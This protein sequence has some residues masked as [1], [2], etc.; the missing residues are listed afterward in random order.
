MK[1]HKWI[2]I[3]LLPFL[4]FTAKASHIVGGEITFECLGDSSYRISL[5]VYRDCY[6]G[7]PLA[8]FDDPAHVG[9][10]NNQNML[11]MVIDMP[12]T[13]M[14]DTLSAIFNDPCLFDPGDV[15]VH[16]THYEKV[17]TLP[18]IPGGYQFVYQRCCRNQT[19]SNIYNPDQTGMTIVTYMSEQSMLECNNG[20]D[21][22]FIPP[23]FICVDKPID[24][25]HSAID[26]EG[27]SLVYKLCTPYEGA[28]YDDPYPDV[29]S[30]PPYDT[31]V[32]VDPPYNLDN[33][34]GT[35]SIPLAI[36]PHTGFMTG[37]PTNQGQYVVSV[38]VEEYRNG[39]LISSMRRDFQYNVGVCGEVT[40]TF[41][42]PEAQCDNLTVNFQNQ[43]STYASDFIWYFQYPDTTIFSME[44]NPAY[45]YPD[46][47]HY[48]IMLVA[49]PGSVCADTFVKDIYLQNNSLFA[50]FN[51]EVFDCSD[52]AVLSLQDLSQDTV[53]PPAYWQW[54]VS[55]NNISLS[56]NEQNPLFYLPSSVSGNIELLVQSVNG[57]EQ[58]LNLPF[59]TGQGFPGAF[60][61]DTAYACLGQTAYLNPQASQIQAAGY[62]WS[63]PELVSD[64]L[65]ANPYA[66]ADTT[67]QFTVEI[68]APD[69]LC[70][71]VKQITLL[72]LPYPELTTPDS[73]LLCP[74][75]SVVLN[76][77]GNPGYHYNWSSSGQPLSDPQ[78]VSPEVSPTESTLYTVE[79]TAPGP[80]T[81]VATRQVLVHVPPPIGLQAINDTVTCQSELSISAQTAEFTT[82]FWF[83]NGQ[84]ILPPVNPLNIQNIS[85]ENT[86]MVNAVDVYGCVASDTFTVA[87]GPVE[88]QTS[89][90]MAEVCT[91]EPLQIQTLNL[92]PNDSLSY[93]WAVTGSGSLSANDIPNPVYSSTSAGTEW[94]IGTFTSQYNCTAQDSV[95]VTSVSGN[96]Q[97]A[98]TY[99]ILCDG[100]TVQFTNQSTNVDS[101][102]WDFGVPDT[103][104]DTSTAVNPIFTFPELGSYQVTL[105]IPYA[106]DCALPATTTIDITNPILQAGFTY[107]YA[108]CEEDSI[109]VSFTDASTNTLTGNINAWQ[110]TFSNGQS[111]NE[112]NPSIYV[113]PGDSPLITELQ[114]FTTINCTSVITDTLEINFLE[115]FLPDT[116][117]LC[118][119]DTVQLNP[120]ADSSYTYSWSPAIG[121]NDPTSGSPLAFPDETTNYTLNISSFTGAD[122][123]Q[124]QRSITVFVPEALQLSTEP[125][126]SVIS[127]GVPV[128]IQANV[129]Q[130]A[131][132]VWTNQ[133]G[134]IIGTGPS[135]TVLPDSIE[136][137][138]LQAANSYNCTANDQIVVVNGT[139]NIQAEEELFLC[140]TDSFQLSLNNADP[141]DQIS[142]FWTAG[143]G[144]SVLSDPTQST[145]WAS[146]QTG[147]T[148]FYYQVENQ[149]GCSLEDS[150][151][152]YIS[153]FSA[154]TNDSVSACYGES[155]FINPQGNPAYDYLWIPATGLDD[156]TS[157]NPLATLTQDQ[158]YTVI[159]SNDDGLTVC[160][161]TQ[162]VLVSVSPDIALQLT[163]DQPTTLCESLDVSLEAGSSVPVDFSWYENQIDGAPFS[164][165]NPLSVTPDGTVTYYVLA[166]DAYGCIDTA[167]I[168]FEAYPLQLSIPTGQLSCAGDKIVLTV[169]NLDSAQQ[170]QYQWQPDSLID[171]I[172]PGQVS[173]TLYEDALIE[174]NISNQIGCTTSASIPVSVTDLQAQMFAEAE[175]DTLFLLADSL[176]SSQLTTLNLPGLV[177]Y[178][179][180][181]ESLSDAGIFN[182]LAFPEETTTYV[183][184]LEDENGC[185]A[186]AEV[187]VVVITPECREPVIFVPNSFTPNADGINDMLF[188]Y[189]N[190]QAEGFFT[191]FYFTVYNRWGQKLF[192]TRDPSQGWDGTFKGVP[193]E[194]DVFG[195]YLEVKCYNGETF[196]KKG[197][198]SLLR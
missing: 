67:R 186:E 18:P 194:P 162:Q 45:T 120:G 144:G 187:R 114:V 35:D 146:A 135:I 71:F 96:A 151:L 55:Y 90:G 92:D 149:F 51:F 134:I 111:S 126:D 167:S 107:Q 181:A 154:A 9:V 193:L 83:E 78:A 31:V 52:S 112:Q 185:Q 191:D 113:Y 76:P 121:L 4:A 109:L 198:V 104:T 97:L 15:C 24:F 128:L 122:T 13:G 133:D 86:Y 147:L 148:T 34:L 43:S 174:V 105:S 165:D 94:V 66:T 178:W 77:G 179:E 129:N 155:T 16:T 101:F 20:P 70:T 150:T 48:Q 184:I 171:L 132:Y 115:V 37:V 42:S 118:Q 29:P 2:F 182:P 12:F 65:A 168:T 27:D 11:V 17:V 80:D 169:E 53:S 156:S 152:V 39:Q 41:F 180:P 117:V 22:T 157:Y 23:I 44:E 95:L 102:V 40:A 175:P 192:E 63:P 47:G 163:A 172:G 127:C 46:T 88:V 85:G 91:G 38:C 61:P 1:F 64:S 69:S 68:Q 5:E 32:W 119:G 81:C 79:I 98:F 6:W 100:L 72:P 158:T 49:D 54:T 59:Q 189:G 196:F 25:D 106:V 28:T 176:Q 123:C 73:I 99:E 74:G 110:W 116:M 26:T 136:T 159:I 62:F 177:Y 21:F 195:Y 188:V 173:L 130:E 3:L 140:P 103:D 145:A 57:C 33:I 30:N 75:E 89:P 139:L 87:G 7:N 160:A 190:N 141:F 93:A 58:N 82:V 10:F 164:Q 161:D 125:S 56:S 137:Y 170:L 138:Y 108:G 131:D 183:V 166:E 50:D 84:P 14:D 143:P 8:Y 36:D 124:I 153:D 142:V 19:I 60:I 197:N